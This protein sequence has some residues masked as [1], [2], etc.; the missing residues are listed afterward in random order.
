MVAWSLCD[1][2]KG[3]RAAASSER[4]RRKATFGERCLYDLN[5]PAA[6]SAGALVLLVV[7]E[8]PSAAALGT[9]SRVR[10]R[11]TSVGD[12]FP[13]GRRSVRPE[14]DPPPGRACRIGAQDR[15]GSGAACAE[16]GVNVCAPVQS[17]V[18]KCAWSNYERPVTLTAVRQVACGL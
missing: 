8:N 16:G 12:G 7:Q 13:S 1:R 15:P 3:R 10:K 2:P 4:R 14:A 11:M 17:Y 6:E 9:V 18:I 5:E